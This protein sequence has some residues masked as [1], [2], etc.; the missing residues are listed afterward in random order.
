MKKYLIFTFIL[1][2]LISLVCAESAQIRANMWYDLDSRKIYYS[3]KY[4]GK[5][6]DWQRSFRDSSDEQL[7]CHDSGLVCLTPYFHTRKE[8][9]LGINNKVYMIKN[10]WEYKYE[11]TAT[12]PLTGN[13]MRKGKSWT[14][15][16]KDISVY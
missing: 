14:M 2:Y 12:N 1:F 16:Y 8:F 6:Y 11:C 4:N 5:N 15:D 9:Y 3:V 10:E 7:S 13:C